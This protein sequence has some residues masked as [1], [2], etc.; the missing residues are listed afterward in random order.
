MQTSQLLAIAA[1][2]VYTIAYLDYNR[3]VLKGE[4]KPN[5][6]T[7][8]I[9]SVISLIST[10]SYFTATRDVWMSVIPLL[11]IVLCIGTFV[12]ALWLKR[13]TRPDIMDFVALT[14]GIIAAVVWKQYGSAKYANFIVQFAVLAGFY[15]TWRGIM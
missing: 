10:S 9:W 6:A 15:P 5:G 8:L 12:L 7:W 11:N 14:I 4:T 2:L 13:F 3:K 1:G